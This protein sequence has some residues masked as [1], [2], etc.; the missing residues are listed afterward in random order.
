MPIEAKI[1]GANDLST[2]VTI[3]PKT[4]MDIF[5]PFEVTEA[6]VCLGMDNGVGRKQ[7]I[8]TAQER[9]A[10]FIGTDT[11]SLRD[12]NS[13]EKKPQVLSGSEINSAGLWWRDPISPVKRG[14]IIFVAPGNSYGE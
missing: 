3:P 11:V 14:E 5:L 4:S 10:E 2:P 12:P 13:P 9:V 7:K 8:L 6:I 1:I